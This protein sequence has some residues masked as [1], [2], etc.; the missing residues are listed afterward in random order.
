MGLDTFGD[1][2]ADASGQLLP[3]AQV[4][5]DVIEEAV[6]ADS[7]GIDFIGLGEHHRA[8]FAISAPE[9]VL[10]AIAGQ[11]TRIR[12]GTA[13]TVLSSDDPIRVFQRFATLDA[14]SN[15]RA[16]VILGRGSFTES[17][18]LFGFP[19]DQYERLFQEKLDLFVEVLKQEPVTWEG[20][21]RPPLVNQSIFP[22]IEHGRLKA[23]IGV[24][25]TPQSVVRAAY[26]QLPLMLAIIGGDPQRFAPFVD[27][28]RR[29][30][31]QRKT[32]MQPVGIHSP[33]YIAA[34]DEQAREEF[35]LPYKGMRDRIGAERGWPP[36]E[37]EE[38]EREIERGSLYLGSPDTVARKI[39]ATVKA[40]GASRF[41]LKYS[42][43]TLSHGKLMTCIELYG[44]EVMP[45]VRQLLA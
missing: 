14:A 44:R 4:I 23:W 12:L 3:H 16:E 6:L 8:D 11:T 37:K 22:P 29:T 21:I 2:T 43:G 32:P 25:G 36:M 30:H 33:G 42:A 31:E 38:F 9:T 24:G 18:P 27:L 5:R 15:G 45:R 28:Y 1:V 19:L 40:L 26:Y 35:W 17:F 39:A 20:S 41:D 13:V 10:A 7:L 34:T